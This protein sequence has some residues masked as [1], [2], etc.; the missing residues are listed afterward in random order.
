MENRLQMNELHKV[1]EKFFPEIELELAEIR[2]PL[3]TTR[4]GFRSKPQPLEQLIATLGEVF[5]EK[6][7]IAPNYQAVFQL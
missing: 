3:P 1:P 6:I 7:P 5:E 4:I 2:K